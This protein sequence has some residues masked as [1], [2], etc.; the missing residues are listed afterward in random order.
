MEQAISRI[1]IPRYSM[2]EELVNSISHGIGA[3][4][5]VVALVLMVLRASSPLATTC[6][7]VFGA[8]MIVLY[9][10]SCLY[11]ALPAESA[12]KRV[13]RVMDHC[14]VFLLVFGTYVPA[15][16]LGVGGALG[17][18]LFGVVGFFTLLGIVFTVI[19]VDRFG[20]VQVVCH[21]ASG[22]SILFGLPQLLG[23]MGLVGMAIVVAGGV[24]YTVGAILYGIGKSRAYMHSV[25]HFF[26]LLGTFLHFYA[27]YAFLL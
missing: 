19:D 6:A 5:S 16:L 10:T 17:W 1:S 22:W 3:V 25:F 11:H 13:V 18:V 14:N 24:A 8:T 15:S 7:C 27:I 12:A 23:T 21:L 9:T 20:M 4:F 2:E 26:C